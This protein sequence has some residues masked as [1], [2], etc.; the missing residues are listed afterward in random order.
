MK[1]LVLNGSPKGNRSNTYQL[2]SAFLSGLNAQEVRECC[3]R[4]RDIKPCLGCFAC[5]NKT[6]GTC[7]LADDM[8]EVII[9]AV[10]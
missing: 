2:A 3:I 4:D 9:E 10:K 5:W 8:A 6:P 7:C 1:I